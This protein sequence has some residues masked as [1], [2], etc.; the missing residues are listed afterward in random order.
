MANVLCGGS[1][2]RVVVRSRKSLPHPFC[3]DCRRIRREAGEPPPGRAAR[4]CEWCGTPL[5]HR[6]QRGRFCSRSCGSR[7]RYR[8][9]TS[10]MR[11]LQ[12][13]QRESAAPGLS[14]V[15]RRRLLAAVKKRRETCT[16]CRLQLAT[17]LDHVIPL[18][19]GGTNYEGNLSPACRR[20]NSSKADR[21]IVEWRSGLTSSGSVSA[22]Q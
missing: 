17:T 7:F 12:R 15:Q 16:Y 4:F 1:C 6:D 18:T 13:S 3:R 20:C 11:K 8:D 22:W 19:R 2:G 5:R 14:W 9:A 10:P 21:L